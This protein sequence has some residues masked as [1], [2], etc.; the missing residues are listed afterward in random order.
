MRR[1]RVLSCLASS[2]Q[3]M[4]SFLAKGVMS[5][6]FASAVAFASSAARRSSGSLCTTPPDTRLMVTAESKSASRLRRSID[7]GAL[8]TERSH[9]RRA[10]QS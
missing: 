6:H 5:S 4:N 2:T 3:Q 1:S 10:T 9:H 8:Q 7:S